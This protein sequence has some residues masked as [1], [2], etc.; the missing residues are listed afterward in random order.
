MVL[1]HRHFKHATLMWLVT[2]PKKHPRVITA[3]FSLVLPSP[4]SINV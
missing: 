2:T 4:T 3:I 1:L